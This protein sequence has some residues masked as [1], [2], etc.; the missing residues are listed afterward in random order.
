MNAARGARVAYNTVTKKGFGGHILRGAGG[1]GFMSL[2]EFGTARGEG[3]GLLYSMGKAGIMGALWTIA[4][5]SMTIYMLGREV[6]P[7]I[8]NAA[9]GRMRR[10]QGTMNRVGRPFSAEFQDS[11]GAMRERVM[12]QQEAM[13]SYNRARSIFGR[14]ASMMS[15]RYG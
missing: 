14:E 13:T 3:H 12:L 10:S 8:G 1:L 4:P 6:A 9:W 7:A 11:P 2:M 5:T 15:R